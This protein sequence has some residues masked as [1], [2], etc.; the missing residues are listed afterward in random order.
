MEYLKSLEA[1]AF[2]LGLAAAVLL[3]VASALHIYWAFGG[4][5]GLY[6]AIPTDEGEFVFRPE[7]LGLF[8]IGFGLALAGLIL[9]VRVGTLGPVAPLLLFE[10]GTWVVAAVFLLRALGDFRYVGLT[11]R[12]WET[13][14]AR[15]D[16]Y[17]Y[18]PLCLFVSFASLAAALSPV[19][20]T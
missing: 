16:T 5:W 6:A 1:A 17:V 3:F 2:P 15:L 4:R 20:G 9:L 7:P 11:K 19:T 14:F 12:V 13:R 10:W 18:S 8:G